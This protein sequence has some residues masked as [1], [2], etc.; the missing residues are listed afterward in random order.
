MAFGTGRIMVISDFSSPVCYTTLLVP[1][2]V[3]TR[4]QDV[5]QSISHCR[6]LS[7]EA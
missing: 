7:W 2:S 3:H 6:A 1:S 4:L 5:W